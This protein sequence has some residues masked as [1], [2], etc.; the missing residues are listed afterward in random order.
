MDEVEGY[1]GK[2]KNSLYVWIPVNIET[3]KDK[4]TAYTYKSDDPGFDQPTNEYVNTIIE[5]MREN[6]FPDY[7]IQHL[8]LMKT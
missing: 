8:I 7:Y 1:T 4:V 6:N 3:E 2:K 5:G